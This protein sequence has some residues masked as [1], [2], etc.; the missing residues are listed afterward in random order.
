MDMKTAPLPRGK[1]FYPL[2]GKLEHLTVT[3][4]SLMRLDNI[5][6]LRRAFDLIKEA[7]AD[8]DYWNVRAPL[9]H[10]ELLNDE[11]YPIIEMGTYSLA[12]IFYGLSPVKGNKKHQYASYNRIGKLDIPVVGSKI[13]VQYDPLRRGLIVYDHPYEGE[14]VG[15]KPMVVN[16]Q[17]K[18]LI[19]EKVGEIELLTLL[20]DTEYIGMNQNPASY[21]KAE[22]GTVIAEL[23][24][25]LFDDTYDEGDLAMICAAM[26]RYDCKW[27]TIPY[28]SRN[29]PGIVK[30]VA[31][32][33]NYYLDTSLKLDGGD[34][35][36]PASV[37]TLFIYHFGGYVLPDNYEEWFDG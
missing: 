6:T 37:R 21:G 19:R 33:F 25:K 22:R 24:P 15:N 9:K 31:D 17:L 4:E 14:L 34:F 2:S 16:K 23:A 1:K 32:E 20:G 26:G 10:W 36:F 29:T 28:N 13:K 30:P 7:S 12:T 35:D 11:T 27:N 8:S 18:S 3:F 5:L